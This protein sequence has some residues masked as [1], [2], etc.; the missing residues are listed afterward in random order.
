MQKLLEQNDINSLELIS[1]LESREKGD[2]DFL[3]IDVREQYEYDAGHIKGVDL[4]KP[5]S[6]FPNLGRRSF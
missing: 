4:L 5:T 6:R 2:I 1:L 3:L